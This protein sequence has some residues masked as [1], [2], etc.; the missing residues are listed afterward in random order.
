MQLL[1]E[2]LQQADITLLLV[3]HDPALAR[4]FSRTLKLEGNS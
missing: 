1:M 4:Y 2:E 3:S